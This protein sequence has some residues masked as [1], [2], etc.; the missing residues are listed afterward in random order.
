VLASSYSIEHWKSRAL[1]LQ[2]CVYDLRDD[3]E[4]LEAFGIQ[5]FK[6]LAS[7][8]VALIEACKVAKVD[9]ESVKTFACNSDFKSFTEIVEPDLVDEYVGRF[10]DIWDVGG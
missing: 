3:N 6:R 5:C 2:A 4:E 9:I 7:L 10:R 8:E 1:M